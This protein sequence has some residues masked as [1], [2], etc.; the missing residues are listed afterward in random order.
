[1]SRFVTDLYFSAKDIATVVSDDIYQLGFGIKY[2]K[3]GNIL[4]PMILSNNKALRD[5]QWVTC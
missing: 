2:L 1:M 3:K 4:Q 5:I